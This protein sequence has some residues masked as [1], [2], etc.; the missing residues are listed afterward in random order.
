MTE[1]KKVSPIIKAAIIIGV[2][3][4]P[5]MYSYF[6]L[7]AF[8]DPYARLEDVPVAVVNLD[9]GAEINGETRNLGNE[10]CDELKEDGTVGFVF[11]DKEDAEEGVLGDKYYASITIPEDFSGNVATISGDSEKIHSTITYSANQ[12]K[13]YL[14]AQI[15]ENA[16]PTIKEKVNS[17]IDGQIIETLSEKLN[18]VPDQMGDLEDGLDKL[19]DG[20][21]QLKD[22][23]SQLSTGTDTL[24]S[25][26]VTLNNGGK[27]LANGAGK[28]DSGMT[29]LKN[30][31]A[32]LNQRVPAL[33]S[34]AN[35]LADGASQLKN[36]TSQLKNQAP[37]LSAGMDALDQGAGQLSQ[38]LST[39]EGNNETLNGGA[40]SLESGANSL[41]S[42]IKNYTEG[43]DQAGA[44]AKNL[45]D[46]IST[47]T[48]GVT[49]AS[50]GA[51]SLYKGIVAAGQAVSQMKGQVSNAKNSLPSND[52]LDGLSSGASNL[53]DGLSSFS[54]GYSSALDAL[55]NYQKDHPDEDMSS[56]IGNFKSLKESLGGLKDGASNVSGG[57]SNLTSG[58]K[59]IKSSV[60][61]LEDGLA[62]LDKSFGND[63]S[64]QSLI[65]GAAALKGGLS[66]VTSNNEV[67]TGGISQLS[68]GLNELK[69]NNDTLNKGAGAL[70]SGASDL[71]N[72][73]SQYTAGVSSASSGAKDLKKGT[74]TA[75]AG[76][77]A[78]ESGAAALD[79]GAGQLKDGVDQLKSQAPTLEKGAEALDSGASQLKKGTTDLKNGAS[80][81]SSGTA[82]LKN[83]ADKL[84]A[85]ASALDSGAGELAEGMDTA[86]NGVKDAVD[87]A[88]DQL[89][90]LKGLSEYGEEP[91]KTETEYVQPVANYGSA[92]APYFMGL[93]LWVGC[94]MIYFGIYLDYER[95]ISLLS[96]DSSKIV[97]RTGA[98]GLIS[99][100]QALLLAVVIKDVLHIAVNNPAMLFGSCIL[101]SLTFMTIVQFCLINLGD[102]GKFVAMLLLILQLTSCAG[103]FPIETQNG[104]FQAINKVLPMTYSTQLFKEAISGTAG[105]N[106]GHS[107]LVLVGFTV[108]FLVLTL[109]LSHNALK[110][111]IER[112]NKEAVNKIHEMKAGA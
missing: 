29:A 38:G 50:S 4:I 10:I 88:N 66:Q 76:A 103:T 86:K 47:Y 83:G 25:G 11:T 110:K 34:G 60:G 100:A 91:V 24:A 77:Q 52:T 39:L 63:N 26:A 106:A 81:L 68:S 21:T 22:G 74:G 17:K 72:G 104:F 84:K 107:A 30:G 102:V 14:A 96:K 15:L 13:N 101:V 71:K 1:K 111:D 55:E 80:K 85:G 42:G 23:T 49:Q 43:V 78:L 53:N 32:Q 20:A 64:R 92:F 93:S 97:L 2:I 89:K 41:A 73:V 46:G 58:V 27:A 62:Q 90:A 105:A 65:G 69:G 82:E 37:Q 59:S 18:S 44:G 95:R 87:D 108:V 31:T 56:V 94:L 19:S 99:A 12:K 79:S 51:E 5:L 28:L 67:L 3:I 40:S 36:G 70:K 16:M 109:V 54:K 45:Q 8:W 75:K 98:F 33:V 9:K 112:I 7:G 57:V 6:Y 48:E 35:Q 61:E